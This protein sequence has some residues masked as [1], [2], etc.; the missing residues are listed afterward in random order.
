[1][2]PAGFSSLFF[3][4]YRFA[5][6]DFVRTFVTIL[7]ICFFVF[8][9][10]GFYFLFENKILT[11]KSDAE[12]AIHSPQADL[13]TL[14]IPK[15][16]EGEISW[17]GTHEFSYHREMYDVVN[18]VEKSDVTIYTCYTDKQEERAI[19]DLSIHLKNITEPVSP[20]KPAKEPPKEFDKYFPREVMV[21]VRHTFIFSVAKP[22]TLLPVD[23]FHGLP[24]TQPPNII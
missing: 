20:G 6:L 2:I 1:M 22:D 17:T 5:T 11:A 3:I 12:E 9:S 21:V 23:L 18:V 13:V 15:I 10:V 8:D 4:C 24:L 16:S 19:S 14:T 7:L